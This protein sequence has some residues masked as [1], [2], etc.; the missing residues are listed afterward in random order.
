MFLYC[1]QILAQICI[2]SNL[3]TKIL[4]NVS[5]E[6]HHDGET[7]HG[8]QGRLHYFFRLVMIKDFVSKRLGIKDGIN[9]QVS[10]LGRLHSEDWHRVKLAGWK[11]LITF[12]LSSPEGYCSGKATWISSNFSIP[13]G[14]NTQDTFTPLPIWLIHSRQG[15]LCCFWRVVRLHQVFATSL[16]LIPLNEEP[17]RQFGFWTL[18]WKVECRKKNH[19]PICVRETPD[20]LNCQSAIQ[21][22]ATLRWN[23]GIFFMEDGWHVWSKASEVGD[24]TSKG[25]TARLYIPK[26]TLRLLSSCGIFMDNVTRCSNNLNEVQSNTWDLLPVTTDS[27]FGR[28]WPFRLQRCS[29]WP[30]VAKLYAA[31]FCHEGLTPWPCPCDNP[32]KP[33]FKDRTGRDAFWKRRG[34]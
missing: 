19:L 30:G 14:L 25:K 32:L 29:E 22:R 28:F 16:S 33:R 7:L 8:E 17:R 6:R 20:V 10:F 27:E 31:R 1:P 21:V 9:L 18:A 15:I 23:L 4:L 26:L 2:I 34:W 11:I 24:A 13:C 3:I 12:S 5:P